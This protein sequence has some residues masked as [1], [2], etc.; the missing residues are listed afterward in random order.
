LMQ[1][2]TWEHLT[3][4][5]ETVLVDLKLP[6][7]RVESQF[8]LK[9]V[10]QALGLVSLFDADR[11]ILSGISSTIPLAVDPMRH[12]ALA[13]VTQE[14]TEAAAARFAGRMCTS[15]MRPRGERL[16]PNN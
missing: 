9:A 4:R 11:A 12:K 15:S 1:P 2:R 10:M 6:R 16:P 14:G 8:D 5:S 13:Q 7:F 3:A